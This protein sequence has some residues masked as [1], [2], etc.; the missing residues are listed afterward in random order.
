MDQYP[1]AEDSLAAETCF[2]CDGAV[3][4]EWHDHTF[5]YGVDEPAPRLSARIPVEVCN[6]CGAESLGYRAERLIHE[7]VCA[8]H[9]VLSPR[10]I[11]TLREDH[12]LS[13]PAFAK[14]TGLGEAA[15]YRWEKGLLIQN[16]AN[17]RY[18]RLLRSAGNMGALRRLAKGEAPRTNGGSDARHRGRRVE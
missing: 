16:R 6:E 10:E 1:S 9:G 13:R 14:I 5:D 12:G 11:R 2:E 8:H 7:A 17:D 18:L 15:L 3:R 4:T